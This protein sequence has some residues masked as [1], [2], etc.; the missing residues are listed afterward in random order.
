LAGEKSAERFPAIWVFSV[1]PKG[2]A[3]G[4][5]RGGINQNERRK[6]RTVNEEEVGGG[7]DGTYNTNEK[8][9]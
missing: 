6:R 8:M 5:G 9:A 3:R 7:S 2:K 4:G 1:G